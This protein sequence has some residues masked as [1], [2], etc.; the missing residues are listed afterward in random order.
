MRL[1]GGEN[2]LKIKGD[3]VDVKR[4]LHKAPDD[5]V[6]ATSEKTG[7]LK[8]AHAVTIDGKLIPKGV[9]GMYWQIDDNDGVKVFYSFRDN[10]CQNLKYV[11]KIFS[12][13]WRLHKAGI[14]TKPKKIVPVKL[15]ITYRGKK[16]RKTGWGIKVRHIRYPVEPWTEFCHGKPYSFAHIDEPWHTPEAFRKFKKEV[17]K[18]L[19]RTDIKIDAKKPSLKLGDIL[20]CT[21]KKR[22]FLCDVG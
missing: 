20:P 11:K 4:E 17:L 2:K 13:A 16:I 19:K 7:Y 15:N 14:C 22:F 6:H 18:V 21:K 9:V 1:L 5:G 10:K 8:G 12:K 3:A